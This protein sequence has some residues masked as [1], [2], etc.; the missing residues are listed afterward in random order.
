MASA[1]EIPELPVLRVGD[2][3]E[4]LEPRRW[5][6]EGLWSASAVGVLGGAPKCCKSW[7]GLDLAVS[8]STGTPCLGRFR[9]EDP[10][11]V[12]VYLAEDALSAVRERVRSIGRD[13][14]VELEDMPLHVITTPTLRLDRGPD[15]S[16]LEKTAERLRPRLLVLDPLV[17]LHGLDENHAGEIAGLLAYFREL[18]RRLDLALLLVHHSRKNASAG[19]QGLRGSG[20][21]HA[22]GDSNLYVRR[23]RERLVLSVEHRSAAPPSPLY[24]KLC[25]DDPERVHLEVTGSVDDEDGSRERNLDEE[26]LEALRRRALSRTDLRSQLSVKNER[27]GHALRRLEES[28]RIRRDAEGWRALPP[29]A[30]VVPRSPSI[31][32][33]GNGPS[34]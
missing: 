15:R 2:I 5:L 28:G 21:L 23:V 19:G 29:G 31:G 14:G 16:R 10:G 32:G 25:S 20:D 34:S 6:V 7:L 33:N 13:R 30:S 24:L 4:E 27:L 11:P 17:R 22:F 1:S 8:V 26:V 9:I 3:P 18:Q 12:L